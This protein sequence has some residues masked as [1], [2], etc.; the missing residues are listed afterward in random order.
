MTP[1]TLLSNRGFSLVETMLASAVMLI[2]FIALAAGLNHFFNAERRI[3]SLV[4]ED[5]ITAS[6][7]ANVRANLDLYQ[8]A[9]IPYDPAGSPGEAA[10]PVEATALVE[11]LPVAF[12]NQVMTDPANCPGCAGRL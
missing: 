4:R 12:N 3:R 10:F 7:I 1:T 6:I 11:D 5:Q 2:V 9:F 8:Q